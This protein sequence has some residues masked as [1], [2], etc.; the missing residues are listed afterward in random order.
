[1]WSFGTVG[2][3]KKVGAETK[4]LIDQDITERETLGRYQFGRKRTNAQVQDDED[5]E[6][7]QEEAVEERSE[8]PQ[9]VCRRTSTEDDEETEVEQEET[10]GDRSGRP[11]R[12][13]QRPYAEDDEE[14]V[15]DG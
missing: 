2:R 6:E 7:E 14:L 1:M 9:H 15:A 13:R 11:Q 12:V 8:R 10:V 5:T 4:A 3:E